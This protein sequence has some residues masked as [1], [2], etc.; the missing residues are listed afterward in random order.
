MLVEESKS[1]F[2]FPV[3]VKHC[4]CYICAFWFFFP[5]L[6]FF[7]EKKTIKKMNVK[8]RREVTVISR[9]AD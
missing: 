3:V 7:L 8:G 1:M 5:T 2:F 4:F 9:P 6:D